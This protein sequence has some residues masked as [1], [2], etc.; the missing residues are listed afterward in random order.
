MTSGPV[1]PP[2]ALLSKQHTSR[3]S[4]FSPGLSGQNPRN[5]NG[6][7]ILQFN[8]SVQPPKT[9]LVSATSLHLHHVLSA[10]HL[11]ASTLRPPPSIVSMAVTAQHLPPT[12]QE[13]NRV[14]TQPHCPTRTCAS[15]LLSPSSHPLTSTSGP[16]T[17]AA[18][19]VWKPLFL[20][21]WPVHYG[22]SGSSWKGHSS[23]V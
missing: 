2:A 12:G 21:E 11:P 4:S 6:S 5:S 23:E 10:T 17:L 3:P 7:L 18:A 15:L 16:T 19:A 13:E 8:P 20:R 22:H 14:P 9:H 1:L